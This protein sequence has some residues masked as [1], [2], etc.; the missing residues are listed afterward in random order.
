LSASKRTFS[1]IVLL[2]KRAKQ[3]PAH[4]EN[5]KNMEN[6]ALTKN[7][8]RVS[9]SWF[10]VNPLVFKKIKNASNSGVYQKNP[11]ALKK[12]IKSD[13]ALFT[14]CVKRL[15]ESLASEAH[16]IAGTTDPC[17]LLDGSNLELCK[18]FIE[19]HQS[20]ISVHTMNSMTGIQSRRMQ[21]AMI[22]AST[23]E[24]L[25]NTFEVEEELAYSTALFRQLGLTL[26][27]WNYPNVY[28]KVYSS[29]EERKNPELAISK[30]L[31]FSPAM[32]GIKIARDWG[33]IPQVRAA[34]GDKV[35]ASESVKTV[36]SLV[37]ICEI[38]EQFA[39]I[40]AE[41]DTNPGRSTKEV[42]AAR[43]EL[44]NLMGE[45]NFKLLLNKLEDSLLTYSHFA[46]R[47]FPAPVPEKAS[48]KQEGITEYKIDYLTKNPYIKRCPQELQRSLTELYTQID[49]EGDLQEMIKQLSKSIMPQAG[50]QKGCVYLVDAASYT[51]FP[52]L[53]I[54]ERRVDDFNPV[55]YLV[56]SSS[57]NIV[58]AAYKSNI[59][60]SH[61]LSLANG[62]K[63]QT[64]AGLLGVFERAGVLYLEADTGTEKHPEQD[65][66]V[67][68]KALRQA[69]N[70]CLNLS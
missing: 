63:A 10:P 26:I 47:I 50:F 56:H 44:K 8:K 28:A 36:D 23:A 29:G 59:P 11:G 38:G 61:E 2:N 35:D 21:Q 4:Q 46:P 70:D 37:K 40:T 22:S 32:L 31:G 16:A 41:A 24:S 30:I 12:H 5:R 17:V 55:Q 20:A 54:G 49:S 62:E 13:Y 18:E 52:R 65:L 15:A 57:D 60:L 25:S 68:F 14:F 3:N 64:F 45:S 34:M 66:L 51:L 19:T 42:Q 53:P 69:L 1:L 39:E 9:D 48:A 58:A 6:Q 67:C 7:Y 27:A 33:L 43:D